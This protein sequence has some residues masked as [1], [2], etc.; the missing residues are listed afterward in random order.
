MINQKA[1][2]IR[3]GLEK[4]I[5]LQYLSPG[6]IVKLKPG[7]IVPADLRILESLNLKVDN[8]LLTGEPEPQERVLECTNEKSALE[9]KNLAFLGTTVVQGYGKGIVISIGDNTL[10]GCI[11]RLTTLVSKSKS[12][13]ELE[14]SR[15]VK[16]VLLI[17]ISTGIFFFSISLMIGY[18]ITIDMQM[19]V[20]IVIG[21]IPEGLMIFL[22]SSLIIS[23]RKMKKQNILVKD[24]KYIE[25]LGSISCIC[26]DKTGTLTENKMTVVGLWYDLQSRDVHNFEDQNLV[27]NLGY[28]PMDNTFKFLQYCGT[29]SNSAKW[30]FL[31]SN[32]CLY[33]NYG[34]YLPTQ[35]V[36]KITERYKENYIT[37]SPREWPVL[38]GDASEIALIRFFQPIYD[39][40]ALRGK[41]PIM[42][43][44]GIRVEIPF[45]SPDKFGVTL[46][47]PVDFG[48]IENIKKCLMFMKGAPEEVWKRCEFILIDGIA[49]RINENYYEEFKNANHLYASSGK[50]VIGMA[51]MWLPEEDYDSEYAFLPIRNEGPNFPLT[52]LT[53]IGLCALEDPPKHKVREAVEKC[54]QAG[55]KVIMITGDQ[56]L[57]ATAIAREV[58]IV[59]SKQTANEISEEKDID[60]Y[61]ALNNSDAIIIHGEEL[62]KIVE[63]DKNLP[64]RN[65]V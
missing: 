61:L 50:R 48:G 10:L 45:R 4:Q 7:L 25:S 30:N 29:L 14:I 23:W 44:Y 32:D 11:T 20:G 49:E 43:R 19:T 18:T 39:V 65:N 62:S 40:D 34:N 55:I 59:T 51:M 54:Q 41:Y 53:F 8:S 15:L 33:D 17:S 16:V 28:S 9:S 58:S 13:F 26:S 2:V 64:L 57:T 6:D 47:E 38:R 22:L 52:G 5:D 46:H 24:L 42:L 63:Q 60:L 35:Q 12:L 3:D 1:I 56:P 21:I 31:P 37:T 27:E 36:E